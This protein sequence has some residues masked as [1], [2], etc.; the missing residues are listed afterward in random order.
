MTL[1]DADPRKIRG[2]PYGITAAGSLSGVPGVIMSAAKIIVEA[3]TSPRLH[4]T[5]NGIIPS[6]YQARQEI[7][8]P[9]GSG[10][11]PNG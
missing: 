8:S 6:G 1:I 4:N 3:L 10:K 9:R 2:G 11:I 7:P 5:A